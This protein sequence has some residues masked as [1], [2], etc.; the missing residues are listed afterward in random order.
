M[1]FGHWT[2]PILMGSNRLGMM[3]IVVIVSSDLLLM[4]GDLNLTAR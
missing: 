2:A 4:Y 3:M 1:R